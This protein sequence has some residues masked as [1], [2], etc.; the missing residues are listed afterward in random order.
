MKS[1]FHL[2]VGCRDAR[3]A[4]ALTSTPQTAANIRIVLTSFE[5]K[6]AQRGDAF[7][8]RAQ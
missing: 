3:D 5:G 4:T 6:R 8:T 1:K 7:C 2:V